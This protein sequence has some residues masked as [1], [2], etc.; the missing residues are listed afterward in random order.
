MKNIYLEVTFRNGKPLAAYL[1]L[2][3]NSGDRSAR[4]EQRHP[5]MLIDYAPDGRPIGI[6]LTSPRTVNL[7][8]LNAILEEIHQAPATPADLAPLAI[9]G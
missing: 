1:Y 7:A 9:A 6:E 4:T 8:A 2:P 3:R 5:S